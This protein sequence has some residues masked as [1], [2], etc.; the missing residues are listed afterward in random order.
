MHRKKEP[1][2]EKEPVLEKSVYDIAR[3]RAEEEEQVQAVTKKEDDSM[4][5][6]QPDS[7]VDFLARY[8]IDL[9]DR[10]RSL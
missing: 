4:P 2:I 3:T 9:C 6:D 7:K 5:T 8:R 1:G 10:C